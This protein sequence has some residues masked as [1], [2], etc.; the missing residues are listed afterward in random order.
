ME[1]INLNQQEDMTAAITA[2]GVDA[3]INKAVEN[4]MLP[5]PIEEEQILPKEKA[6]QIDWDWIGEREGV[7]Y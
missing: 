3:D 2:T 7:G 4:N 5:P 1:D 6:N